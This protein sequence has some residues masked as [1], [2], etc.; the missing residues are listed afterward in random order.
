MDAVVPTTIAAPMSAPKPPTPTPTRSPPPLRSPV[1]PRA[2]EQVLEQQRL[3]AREEHADGEGDDADPDEEATV[4]PVDMQCGAEDLTDRP[5]GLDR[6]R[7][8]RRPARPTEKQRDE[9]DDSRQDRECEQRVLLREDE[10]VRARCDGS[11]EEVGDVGAEVVDS[12]DLDARVTLRLLLPRDRREPLI[13]RRRAGGAVVEAG[14]LLPPAAGEAEPRESVGR[15]ST[16]VGTTIDGRSG[17]DARRARVVAAESF[18]RAAAHPDRGRVVVRVRSAAGVGDRMRP[19][20]LE[21]VVVP[22]RALTALVLR[23]RDF[24]RMRLERGRRVG[25]VEHELDHLPVALVL[26]VPVVEDVEEP[27]LEGELVRPTAFGR[28]VRVHRRAYG[29]RSSAVR[30]S[31]R[32]SQARVDSRESRGSSPRPSPY[33]SAAVGRLLRDVVRAAQHHIGVAEDGVHRDRPVGLPVAAF[34]G[35]LLEGENGRVPVGQLLLGGAGRMGRRCGERGR[36]QPEGEEP[37]APPQADFYG[38]MRS[39]TS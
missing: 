23:E 27:V 9:P 15:R 7:Q 34:V 8:H 21:L 30:P 18:L 6:L 22:G 11:A 33:R 36:D 10:R 26:V 28:N 17:V 19:V 14:L 24:V 39:A 3:H 35:L 38:V 37:R 20:P 29:P 12:R 25:G 5:L 4:R 1:R 16:L 31:R 2:P 32:C 13:L